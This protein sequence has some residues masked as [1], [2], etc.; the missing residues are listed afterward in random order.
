[1]N[2]DDIYETA[3]ARG[4]THSKRHFSQVM[5]GKSPSYLADKR[6]SA[7]SAA[8]LLNLYRRLVEYEQADLQDVAFARLLD[9]EGNISDAAQMQQ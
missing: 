1:M 8:A 5:L 7:C 9:A 3:K 4:L 2:I 6:R